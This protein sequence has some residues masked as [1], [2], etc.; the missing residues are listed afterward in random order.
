MW[1]RS[2]WRTTW[3]SLLGVALLI[4]FTA[5]SAM[6]AVAGAQR[7]E[8]A[9]DRFLSDIRQSEVTIYTPGALDP[10]VSALITDDSRIDGTATVAVVAAGPEPLVPG[11]EAIVVSAPDSYWGGLHR[12][13]L[14]DGRAPSGPAEVAMTEFSMEHNGLAIGDVIDLRLLRLDELLRCS[15]SGDCDL[16]ELAPSRSPGSSARSMI[17]RRA[18]SSTACSSPVPIGSTPTAVR[19]SPPGSRPSSTS[20]RERRSKR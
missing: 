19:P 1:V 8:V 17:S 13:C 20:R 12:P 7:A 11:A 3:R 14:I 9:L 5:G 2:E 4:A 15:A 10:A 16:A 18:R 6:A